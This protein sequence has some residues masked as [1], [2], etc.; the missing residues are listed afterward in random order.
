[1][2]AASIYVNCL[3]RSLVLFS[4][5]NKREIYFFEAIDMHVDIFTSQPYFD[6]L[7]KALVANVRVLLLTGR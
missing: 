5:N 1:M 3:H 2:I 7:T 4:G 6:L